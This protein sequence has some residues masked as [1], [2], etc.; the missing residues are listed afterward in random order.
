[1]YPHCQAAIKIRDYFA[2]LVKFTTW[3]QRIHSERTT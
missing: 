1:L 3:N 2:I